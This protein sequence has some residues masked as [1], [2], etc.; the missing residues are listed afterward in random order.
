MTSRL[1]TRATSLHFPSLKARPSLKL[2]LL[3]PLPTR[4]LSNNSSLHPPPPVPPPA[5]ST[6]SSAAAPK[7]PTTAPKP[8]IDIRHIRENPELYAQNCIERNYARQSTYPFQIRSLFEQWKRL[9]TD[10][11]LL[12]EE[13]N[14]TKKALQGIRAAAGK[15]VD[16]GHGEGGQENVAV[17]DREK[18]LRRARELKGE[19]QGVEEAEAGLM[20]EMQGLAEAIPNLTSDDTPRGDEPLLLSYINEAPAGFGRTEPG[21]SH[22][23]IGTELGIL[24]FAAAAN[25]SGWG[26]Y[27][28]VDGAA[29]LEHALTQYAL[30]VATRHGWRQVSPPTMVYSYVADACGFQPRDQNGEQQIYAIARDASDMQRGR[31]E[32]CLTGTS[33]IALAGMK[34][35]TTLPAESLPLRRVAA[36]RCYRAEAGSRGLDTKGLYRVHE[37]TKVE[38]FAWTT[39]EQEATEQVFDEILDIQTEILSSLGLYCRVLE[40]PSTDLGASATRKCDIEAYFPSR[41][42]RD[43]GW[44]EVTSASICTDYQ[45]RRLGT[46]LRSADAGGRIGGFPWTVNG[47]ALAVPRVVAALLENGWD[48][49]TKSVVI[50]ECLRP[51]MDGKERIEKVEE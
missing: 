1:A 29:Q 25:A 34:A 13:A 10:S 30:A 8:I 19:L 48:E 43:A 24:D 33:E 41:V 38:L 7:R 35:D 39:P 11:R 47:T 9:Q 51:W 21:K 20:E 46:R 17:V 32:L 6:T 22:V 14:A 44:G 27:Y 4:Y 40:M 26:W 23:D 16:H 15:T 18:V 49:A 45:T 31:P 42:Q 12:R 37:F 36:S 2:T 28:L 3:S 5:D 50:P